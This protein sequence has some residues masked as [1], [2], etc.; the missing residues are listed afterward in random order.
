MNNYAF[1]DNQNVY[2][3]IKSQGWKIDW[4]RFRIYLKE[5][6]HVSK[7]FVFIGYIESNNNLYKELKDAG[8]IC[9]FKPVLRYKDGTVK[10]NIDAELV[11]Y[12]MIE[13]DNFDRAIIVTG[14]G[15]FHCLVEHFIKNNK[16]QM[17]LI[18]NRLKYS[19]LLKRFG[20][21]KIT[22]MNDLKG[23]IGQK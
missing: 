22:F 5:H 11:M 15:D 20:K 8:F 17:V 1:I 9:V 3:A 21:K 23:K 12:A 19:A 4:K 13:I 14:D 10:G 2:R 18:P 6:Y 16:L 7:S